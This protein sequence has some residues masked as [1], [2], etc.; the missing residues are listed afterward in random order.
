MIAQ[1]I[2]YIIITVITDSNSTVAYNYFRDIHHLLI[3]LKR[4][5]NVVL[6]DP[7]DPPVHDVS[8][9][10]VHIIKQQHQRLFTTLHRYS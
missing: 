5:S 8:Q 10:S 7:P 9:P 1:L 6:P 4:H 3:S 2:P